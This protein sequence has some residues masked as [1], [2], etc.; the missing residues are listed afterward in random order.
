VLIL[1]T[2]SPTG[3]CSIR[4]RSAFTISGWGGL[5]KSV[6]LNIRS[7]DSDST[8]THSFTYPRILP[9]NVVNPLLVLTRSVTF[10]TVA[11]WP[12]LIIP[13][14]TWTD[15]RPTICGLSGKGST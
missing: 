4:H 8:S 13:Q 1:T 5:C 15:S 7:T 9:T 3:H 6:W 14:G 10:S 11:A 2:L 12:S